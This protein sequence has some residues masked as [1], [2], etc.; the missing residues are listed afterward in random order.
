M[1]PDELKAHFSAMGVR[2]GRVVLV[3][4]SFKSLGPVDGGPQ[5]VLDVLRAMVGGEGTLVMPAYNFTSWTEGHYFDLAHTKSEMG[6]LTEFSRRDPAFARTGH[7]IYSFTAAG[8]LAAELAAI[9]SVASYGPGSVFDRLHRENA[10][11]VSLGLGFNATFTMTHHV[12][13]ISGACRYRYEKPFSGIYIGRDGKPALKTYSMMVRDVAQGVQ[14]DIIPAM[15]KLVEGG[16]I[17]EHFIDGALCHF[18]DSR[19]F[20]DALLPIVRTHPEMLHKK[21]KSA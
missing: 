17:K 12:E 1:T 7:P 9:E 5:G 14:T 18:S 15:T 16:A 2:A 19:D 11:I 4:S 3:H 8:R 6:V 21:G 20:V 13:S 10:A